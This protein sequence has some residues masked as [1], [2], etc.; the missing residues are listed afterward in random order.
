MRPFRRSVEVESVSD[1]LGHRLVLGLSRDFYEGFGA[2]GVGG[3]A[4]ISYGC[5]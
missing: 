2:C 1:S 5:C 3:S 4:R